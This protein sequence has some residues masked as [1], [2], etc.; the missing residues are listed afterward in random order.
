MNVEIRDRRRRPPPLCADCS[1]PGGVQ[2][3]FLFKPR[4]RSRALREKLEIYERQ[5]VVA[6]KARFCATKEK[7]NGATRPIRNEKFTI[8]P[9]A[10]RES[11][12]VSR[13]V[14]GWPPNDT[15]T[16]AAPNPGGGIYAR[17][18][19]SFRAECLCQGAGRECCAPRFHPRGD[20]K[21]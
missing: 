2:A 4:R 21:L 18:F 14:T 1:A 6:E 5:S 16:E 12:T 15:R 9:N 20:E 7:K 11:S 13:S 17:E 19:I 3:N 10:G 8:R